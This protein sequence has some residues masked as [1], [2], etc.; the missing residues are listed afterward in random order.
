[1]S[2]DKETGRKGELLEGY[3]AWI[4]QWNMPWLKGGKRKKDPEKKVGGEGRL[5]ACACLGTAKG[6]CKEMDSAQFSY[7]DF[8]SSEA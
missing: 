1:M 2:A 5:V 6:R 4:N 3:E 7:P 8:V